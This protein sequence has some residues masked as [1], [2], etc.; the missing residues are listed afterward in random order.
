MQV[1]AYKEEGKK[2]ALEQFL[3]TLRDKND[4]QKVRKLIRL[5]EI[6]GFDLG[7]PVSKPLGEGLFELRDRARGFRLYYCF[8]G[9]TV[10]ILLLGGDKSSQEG[11]IK[12]AHARRNKLKSGEVKL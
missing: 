8:Y 6:M 1:L 3:E 2:D 10:A 4:I 9:H 5:L 7:M 11:D 12:K